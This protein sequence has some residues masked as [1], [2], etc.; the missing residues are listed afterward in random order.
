[1]TAAELRSKEPGLRVLCFGAG[2]I[3]T[4]IG[5]SLALRGHQVVFQE[6]P[7]VASELA[8][9]GL[10]LLIDGV[11][12][13]VPNP[14]VTTSLEE[15]MHQAPYDFAIV[16]LKSFD[17]RSLCDGLAAFQAAM[18]PILCLQNGVEN[19]SILASALGEQ[20]VIPGTVTSSIGRRAAG[21]IVLE[22]LRGVGIAGHH[23]LS[24]RLVAS[25]NDA[26]LNARRYASAAGMKW[27]KLITNL[28]ANA[29]SA[30]LDM[31]PAEIFSHSTLFQLEIQQL[32]EALAVMR[33][34]K[35]KVVNLPGTPVRLFAFA[36]RYLPVSL[37]R[38]ILKGAIG[39]GRGG[40]MPSFHIDLH[41]GRG[42]SEVGYLN[43]AVADYGEQ[44]GLATPANQF[45]TDTLTALAMGKL[46]L[47]TYAHDADKF[48]RDF[49]DFKRLFDHPIK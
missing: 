17:T 11:E 33:R 41:S 26:G 46:P 49:D 18:P 48:L 35:I 25:F 1:M 27:S 8:S 2:A 16:A 13:H 12:K 7:Q 45:L 43:G 31:T 24:S 37:S 6:V 19:E 5:G 32:R 34:Q 21:D 15:T 9:R 39:G 42:K 40:K 22:R 14:L 44:L 10:R 29:S 4:Y 20:L 28:P 3:G 38:P 30:I 23:P 36:I 47:K